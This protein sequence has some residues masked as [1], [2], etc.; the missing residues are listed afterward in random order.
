MKASS[1]FQ[2]LSIKDGGVGNFITTI[3]DSFG[4]TFYLRYG[5]NI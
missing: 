2:R 1:F 3:P 5:W 4:F